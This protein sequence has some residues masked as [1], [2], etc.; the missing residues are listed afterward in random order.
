MNIFVINLKKLRWNKM[1]IKE[2]AKGN[3]TCHNCKKTI[4]KG[5]K[6]IRFYYNSGYGQSAFNFCPKCLK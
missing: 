1:K 4:K 2:I 5:I 3:R 6:H